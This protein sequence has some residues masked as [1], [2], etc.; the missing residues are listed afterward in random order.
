MEALVR[1]EYLV[2]RIREGVFE[3]PSRIKETRARLGREVH[4]RRVPATSRVEIDNME[5]MA[6]WSTQETIDWNSNGCAKYCA[7]LVQ[8]RW[9]L[10]DDRHLIGAL[11][12]IAFEPALFTRH[13]I[14]RVN[15][16]P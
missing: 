2:F 5:S 1:Q 16:V 13:C 11:E 14:P 9:I 8:H 12:A 6:A 3:T 10:G 15:V 4:C 7:F